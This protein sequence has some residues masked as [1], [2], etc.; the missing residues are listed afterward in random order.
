[1]SALGYY[2]EL[3]VAATGC[4]PADADQVEDVMRHTIF[5]STLDWQTRRQF[6][7]GARE[8]WAIVQALRAHPQPKEGD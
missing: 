2:G 8:A 7:K 4:K 6:N 1:M 3:I 5:H